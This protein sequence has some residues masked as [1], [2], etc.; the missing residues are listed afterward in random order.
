MALV[1]DSLGVFSHAT[2]VSLNSGTWTISRDTTGLILLNKTNHGILGDQTCWLENMTDP[3]LSNMGQGHYVDANNYTIQTNITGLPLTA[4]TSAYQ[5]SSNAGVVRMGMFSMRGFAQVNSRFKGG[6]RFQGTFGQGGILASAAQDEAIKGAQAATNYVLMILGINDAK[7]SGQT[8]A[9]VAAS[10]N[11][12]ID[13]ITSR[14]KKVLVVSVP[15]MGTAYVGSPTGSTVNALV[16]SP[17]TTNSANNL[18][19]AHCDGV[20][21][22]FLNLFDL[23]LDVSGTSNGG[24]G[25]LAYSYSVISDGLHW[26]AWTWNQLAGLIYTA[27]NANVTTHDIL[28]RSSGSSSVVP[29]ATMA[30]DRS[31]WSVVG[32]NAGTLFTGASGILPSGW[33]GQRSQGSGTVIYS[34]TDPGDGKGINVTA[35]I[36]SGGTTDVFITYPDN[37]TGATIA[38]G[39]TW[40]TGAVVNASI[41]GTS[42]TVNSVTSGA[43]VVGMFLSGTGVTAGTYITGPAVGS[44]WP[45]SVSQTVASTSITATPIGPGTKMIFACEVSWSNW[46]ASGAARLRLSVTSNSSGVFGSVQGGSDITNSETSAAWIGDSGTLTLVTGVLTV[47]PSGLTALVPQ[48]EAGFTA[49]SGSA[50]V[51]NMR[52]VVYHIVSP[53]AV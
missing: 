15:P 26:T 14:G 34:S 12:R 42:M 32:S 16:G 9:S 20:N 17:S 21:A 4:S 5:Q 40:K 19:Q 38:S 8:S 45:V 29:F 27:I 22:I 51:L 33:G 25:G 18:V 39:T 43:L 11:A 24:T 50:L 49:A 23:M 7:T 10:V 35:T 28:P 3:T 37:N 41:S 53:S 52:D 36:S 13:D 1:S 31:I 2:I 30:R 46:S 6:L 48:I 44:V 47:P